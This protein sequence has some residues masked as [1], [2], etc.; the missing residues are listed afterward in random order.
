M[1]KLI[2]ALA[3]ATPA[4]VFAANVITQDQIVQGSQC[5]GT[6]CTNNM[7]FGFDTLVIKENN[8][9]LLF[10]D[11]S[12]SGSFPNY[13]WRLQANDSNNGGSNYFSI[14]NVTN[15]K[16]PFKIDGGAGN[17]AL[18][19]DAQGDIG[20]GTSTP[21]VELQVTD[22]DTP[23]LRLEQDG[24]A[25]WTSQTWDVAGNETNFFIRDVTNSSKLPFRIMPGTGDNNLVLK[26]GNVGVMTTSPTSTLHVKKSDGTTNLHIEETSSTKTARNLLTI[27]NNGNPQIV[28]NNTGKSAS[29]KIS[30]GDNFVIKNTDDEFVAV[31]SPEGNLTLLGDVYMATSDGRTVSLQELISKV[32]AAHGALTTQTP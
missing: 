11:T 25:G 16:V 17:N 9:R 32:E 6:D 19:I 13:D 26:G 12:S 30:A 29:W 5:V 1:K 21:A 27:S 18:I 7:S 4:T 3:L 8:T 28:L 15:T 22:G 20:I 31:V 14:E 24:S 2:T 23:T 10:D